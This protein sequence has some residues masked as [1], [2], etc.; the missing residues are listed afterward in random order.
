MVNQK[1]PFVNIIF[2]KYYKKSINFVYA[3]LY[4]YKK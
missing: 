2:K 1:K 4:I 3:F